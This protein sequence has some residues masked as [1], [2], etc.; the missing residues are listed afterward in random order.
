MP[1]RRKR[2]SGPLRARAALSSGAGG[3]SSP[4]PC[5]PLLFPSI[6]SGAATAFYTPACHD[7]HLLLHTYA[8][9][10]FARDPYFFLLCISLVVGLVIGLVTKWRLITYLQLQ[11]RGW[12]C[13]RARGRG[14]GRVGGGGC[15]KAVV[16]HTNP[17]R[18]L[19][20]PKRPTLPV[21]EP[22]SMA[23]S[24]RCCFGSSSLSHHARLLLVIVA[25][26]APRLASGC[27][28]CVRRSRAAYYTSSLTL[29]GM[30]TRRLCFCSWF[31]VQRE[32]PDYGSTD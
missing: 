7:V 6:L 15:I 17:P 29:T 30:S 11:I 27:D 21:P 18:S 24:V 28:R 32:R 4:V 23:V 9:S 31:C 26:L 12:L 16:T 19:S 3:R 20:S 22:E 10:R 1:H 25:L 14:R 5:D 13:A 2:P 8:R